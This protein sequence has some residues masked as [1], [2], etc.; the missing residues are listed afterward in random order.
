MAL[1]T[2]MGRSRYGNWRKENVEPLPSNQYLDTMMAGEPLR[3]G[4]SDETFDGLRTAVQAYMRDNSI[5][6]VY[7]NDF[8]TYVMAA[9]EVKLQSHFVWDPRENVIIGSRWDVAEI[10][11]SDPESDV[12]T[13]ATLFT[14]RSS[15]FSSFRYPLCVFGIGTVERRVRVHVYTCALGLIGLCL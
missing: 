15:S 13:Y 7:F 12:A 5:P 6:E 1:R 10:D 9:D 11:L 2:V 3:H 14:L 8:N 4:L